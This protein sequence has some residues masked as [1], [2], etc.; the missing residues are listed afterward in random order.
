ML[1]PRGNDGLLLVI[2]CSTQYKR[3]YLLLILGCRGNCKMV[4]F[5]GWTCV[6]CR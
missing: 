1:F 6:T 3:Y 4:V 2:F 5:L